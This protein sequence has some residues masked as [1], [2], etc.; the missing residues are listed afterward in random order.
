[1]FLLLFLILRVIVN[2]FFICSI[3]GCDCDPRG[4]T[5]EGICDSITDEENVAGRCHCKINVGGRRCDTCSEGFWNLDANNTLGCEPCTCNTLGT[6]GN[7]G[8][9]MY[10][11]ECVC[12]RL[13][14]GKDCNQCMPETFGLSATQDGCQLCDCNS[15]GSY[16]N[17]CDVISGQCACRENMQGRRCDIPKQNY[18][19][20]SLHIT[21]E[22]E[23][24]EVA[25]CETDSS[26][27]V[28]IATKRFDC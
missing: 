19:V 9:N 22:A 11:G 10:T 6:V 20:P 18:F 4:S 5:D 8:C 7:L 15:G 25:E 12:K 27:G 14:T 1:M 16:D 13:V 2:F 28:S 26:F 23:L 21:Y 17:H 24:P 3:A